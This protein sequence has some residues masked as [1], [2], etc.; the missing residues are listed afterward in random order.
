MTTILCV[1]TDI[2]ITMA[3][4]TQSS[5]NNNRPWRNEKIRRVGQFLVGGAG[6]TSAANAVMHHWS[7][8]RATAKDRKDLLHFMIVKIVPT[9]RKVIADHYIPA[10]GG[11]GWAFLFAI[12]GEIFHIEDDYSVIQP[13]F[14]AGSI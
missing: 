1:K 10:Q 7:P 5:D 13:L 11:G 14:D 2:G 3:G 12:D 4:D 6:D 9:L 8:P